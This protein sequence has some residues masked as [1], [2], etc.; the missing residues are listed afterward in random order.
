MVQFQIVLFTGFCCTHD[1]N[2]WG[3][4][5]PLKVYIQKCYFSFSKF[6]LQNGGCNRK[7]TILNLKDDDNI[8]MK[9]IPE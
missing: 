5:N 3:N 4:S 6:M 7:S 2:G 1:L 9:F 8:V